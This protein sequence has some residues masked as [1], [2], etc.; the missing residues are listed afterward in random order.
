MGIPQKILV[1]QKTYARNETQVKI[2][3][4]SSGGFRTTKG[5]KH[6]CGLSP[7]LFT[8]YLESVLYNWNNKCRNMCLPMG[9]QTIHHH[10]F[11]D[12]QVIL[13]QD[14]GDAELTQKLIEE[15]QRWGLNVNILK[16][17]LKCRK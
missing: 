10:L 15:Y 6:G 12:V 1:I 14:K 8:V 11:A 9:N 2:R 7:T 16:T 4:Y 13:A 17:V 5:L 3:N